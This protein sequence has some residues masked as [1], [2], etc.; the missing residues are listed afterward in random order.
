M[1]KF[2][3]I[4]MIWLVTGIATKPRLSGNMSPNIKTYKNGWSNF[5]EILSN[6]VLKFLELRAENKVPA[7]NNFFIIRF[8]AIMHR[9]TIV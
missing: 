7:E 2:G 9:T 4:S 1:D 5:S 6:A 3:H 8:Y